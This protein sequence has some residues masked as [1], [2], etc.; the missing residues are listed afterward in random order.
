M[1]VFERIALYGH[2]EDF[3]PTRRPEPTGHGPGSLGKLVELTQRVQ[4]GQVLHLPEDNRVAGTPE[5]QTECARY[6]QAAAKAVR[7][8][9]ELKGTRS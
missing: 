6:V 4:L 2:D 7:D 9:S 8:A 5:Q 1:N 3:M